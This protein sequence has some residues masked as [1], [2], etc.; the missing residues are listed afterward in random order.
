MVASKTKKIKKVTEIP[1]ATVKIEIEQ[2]EKEAEETDK[3]EVAAQTDKPAE[4]DLDTPEKENTEEKESDQ[5]DKPAGAAQS[6]SSAETEKQP[7]E[8]KE[9]EIENF[10]EENSRFSWS[11]V[12][13]FILI[14]AFTGFLI[15]AAYL[16][17]IEDYNFKLTKA[18]P[19][20]EISVEEKTT[21]TP[22]AEEVDKSAY[23]ITV[24]N[25]SGIAG[26]AA[27]VQTLL[28]DNG[29]SVNEIG[30]AENAD[31]TKTQILYVKS[32]NKDYLD[33]LEKTLKTRGSV[34]TKKADSDQ[35]EDVV[36]IVGSETSEITATP[37][38][39]LE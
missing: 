23:K 38:P 20:K 22:M 31:Y 37:T 29:F 7:E 12:I 18:E 6:D 26:E 11:K 17:F 32:V 39:E 25:G 27:N 5:S 19:K 1:E 13:L 33:A 30:N 8:K 34:E 4:E 2:T 16:F 3:T 24:L 9:P 35:T 15:I 28:K 10:D 14:A 21:P 36:V